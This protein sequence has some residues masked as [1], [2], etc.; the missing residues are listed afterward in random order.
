M[1]TASLL[2]NCSFNRLGLGLEIWRQR[3]WPKCAKE[4][5]L[6]SQSGSRETIAVGMIQQLIARRGHKLA[7]E[8]FEIL[9][10]AARRSITAP[11]IK[12]VEFLMTD[13]EFAGRFKPE[14]LTAAIVEL[15]A[16]AEEEAEQLAMSKRW[17][18]WRAV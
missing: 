7:R 16:A 10:N 1:R 2:P 12:A 8:I 4:P 14:D 17:P 15:L 9:A 5:A 13:V 6:Q 11:H 3:Y 18:L